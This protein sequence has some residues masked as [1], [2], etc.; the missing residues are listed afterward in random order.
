MPAWKGKLTDRGDPRR[1]RVHPPVPRRR[2]QA[3]KRLDRCVLRSEGPPCDASASAVDRAAVRSVAD[4]FVSHPVARVGPRSMAGG[5]PSSRQLTCTRSA[6][7]L[8]TIASATLL[9]VAGTA[10]TVEVHVSNGLPGFTIVGPARRVVSRGAR[11]GAGRAALE[12]AALAQPA[13]HGQPG[14]DR[15]AQ[16]GC[17]PRPGHRHGPAGGRRAGPGRGRGRRR[18]SSASSASTASIRP[19]PGALPLV[20]ALDA[21]TVVVAPG[22]AVGGAAGGPPRRAGRGHPGRAARPAWWATSPGRRCPRPTTCR[23][24]PIR[25]TWPTCGASPTPAGPS[26]WP[27]PAATT[28]S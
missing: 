18:P 16:V 22:S 7:M 19:V 4:T 25:P 23:R 3:L 1:G 15:G 6:A 20:D 27:P 12:R 13:G 24:C 9:G 21:E 28:C 17:R 11:P 2:R 5:R 14:A 10:V 8:A 26:R